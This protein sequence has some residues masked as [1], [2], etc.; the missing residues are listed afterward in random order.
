MAQLIKCPTCGRDVSIKA[1]ACP[2]C[3]EDILMTLHGLYCQ[4]DA[5]QREGDLAKAI[6]M[7]RKLA[8]LGHDNA[9]SKLG[10]CYAY[11]EGVPVD[12]AKAAEWYTKAAEQGNEGAKAGLRLLKADGKI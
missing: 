7:F 6:E 11:G 5:V 10:Q 8:E 4:A 12:Y 1:R 3:G 9:Q 2:G